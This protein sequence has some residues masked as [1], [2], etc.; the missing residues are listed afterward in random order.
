MPQV[1]GTLTTTQRDGLVNVQTE[2]FEKRYGDLMGQRRL[3]SALLADENMLGIC[4]V[5]LTLVDTESQTILS[6]EQGEAMLKSAISRL[7]PK[8]R[9]LLKYFD[10]KDLVA[11]IL[12][13]EF[14]VIPILSNLAVNVDK[15][16]SGVGLKLCQDVEALCQEWGFDE[17]WLQVEEQ[18]TPAR[19]LYEN[20]LGYTLEWK[21]NGGSALRVDTDDPS[22]S[23]TE[24]AA[25]LLV[26]SKGFNAERERMK[27]SRSEL[28]DG[29]DGEWLSAVDESTGDTYYYNTETGETSWDPPE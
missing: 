2:D 24:V 10:V 15:R 21:I 3:L 13:G 28:D 11:D 27:R 18:N 26:L 25:P 19:K 23:F 12:P 4:G 14:D 17:V 9:R 7:G 1:D 22:G 5:E 29:D 20:K 16:R 8:E 6:R